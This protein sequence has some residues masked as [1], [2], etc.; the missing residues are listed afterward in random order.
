MQQ[1]TLET[2]ETHQG[3]LATE[4]CR[5]PQGDAKLLAAIGAWGGWSIIPIVV[6]A[7]SVVTLVAIF[8]APKS[9]RP[10]EATTPLPFGPGLCLAGF[11]AVLFSS[12]I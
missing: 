1:T 5:A 11:A 10:V 7:G 6:F 4:L 12:S 9:K 3:I 2:K 8:L